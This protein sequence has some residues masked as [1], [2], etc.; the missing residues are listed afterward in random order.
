VNVN[1][2]QVADTSTVGTIRIGFNTIT[3]EQGNFRPGIYATADP[4][5]T[6]SR[7]GDIWFNKNFSQSNFLV[8]W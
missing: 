1:F 5:S 6:E 4:P 3:D 7:G 8:V 2:V